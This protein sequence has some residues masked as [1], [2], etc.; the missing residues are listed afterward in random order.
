MLFRVKICGVTSAADARVVV[1]AGADAIGLNFVAGSPR[2][3]DIARAVQVAAAVPPG[4][5]KVG[6]FA[7]MPP[8]ETARI[9]AAVGL[10]AIQLH[11][12]LSGDGPGVD[13]PE[14]CA[15]LGSLPL[16][17][18]VRMEPDG[19][20]DP[21]AAARRWLAAAR[22][23]GAQP[24]IV[25]VEAAVGRETSPGHLG[26]TG[27]ACD[28]SALGEARPLD[29]PQGL[30]GGLTPENVARAIAASRVSAVDAASGVELAPGRKDPGKVRAFVA[31]ARAAFE[32]TA[33]PS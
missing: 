11:G 18:A 9:V 13:P 15:Q 30:A 31:A 6:V 4:V 10:D 12:H 26:G 22:A 28:W 20:A 19:M 5:L 16:V 17:R 24:A 33:K 1:D 23:A 25:I 14:R 32:D 8:S 3:L 7:G 29:V 2:H 21:L 27:T